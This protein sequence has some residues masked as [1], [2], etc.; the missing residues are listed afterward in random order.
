MT[1]LFSQPPT[2]IAHRGASAFAPENTL[3][4]FEQAIAQSASW[5]ELDV[6]L[7][8]DEELIVHHDNNFNRIL[9]V[10]SKVAAT[11]F[12]DIATKDAG[13]WFDP[14]FHQARISTLSEVIT[15]LQTTGT[16]VNVEIKPTLGADIQ[17]AL[18][19]L[20]I[21][22]KEWITTPPHVLLS[23]FSLPALT[24]VAEYNQQ[25]QH[26][27]PLALLTKIITS[28]SINTAKRL[29][30]IGIHADQKVLQK[31]NVDHVKAAGLYLAC[32]T[33]NSKT[34]ANVLF[35]MGVDAIF[36]DYPNLT[37]LPL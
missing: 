26:P 23:S 29:G 28:Q 30:C 9:Q 2:L 32:Y 37:L 31:N 15:L 16:H 14:T 19:T 21:L 8:H 27:F 36:S 1:S 13:S 20:A 25:S 17:T 6:M 18:K 12:Q 33:V 22:E 24:T 10:D 4:A 11:N 35:D 34:R 5:V 3:I 7:T